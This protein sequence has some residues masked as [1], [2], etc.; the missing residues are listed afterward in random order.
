MIIVLLL[1]TIA[2]YISAVFTPLILTKPAKPAS[3][4]GLCASV[5]S[6]AVAVIGLVGGDISLRFMPDAIYGGFSLNID[7]LSAYF[8]LMT[9]VVGAAVS[10]YGVRYVALQENPRIASALGNLFLFLLFLI[11]SVDNSLEFIFVWETMALVTFLLIN[12]DYSNA[13]VNRAAWIYFVAAQAGAV[14]III[15]FTALYSCYQS[16]DFAVYKTAAIAPGTSIVIFVV[17]FIGFSIKAGMVPAHGWLPSAHAV[18]PGN[19]SA[20]LSG[21]ML[22]MALYGL[23]RFGFQFCAPDSYVV[24]LVVMAFGF[25]S[26]VYGIYLSLREREIKRILACS[27]IENM[28]LIF[29]LTGVSLLYK[30]LG[31][32]ILSLIALVA[33]LLH[34]FNHA[35][36]KSALFLCA[37]TVM[38]ITHQGDIEQLGGLM[39]YMP[40]IGW[41]FVLSGVAICGV[42]LFN[43]FISEWLM[44]KSIVLLTS[45]MT[46]FVGKAVVILSL[47]AFA[48]TIALVVVSF[49]RLL[50]VTFFGT[51]R[52]ALPH[53]SDYGKLLTLPQQLLIVIALVIGLLPGICVA[54][55]VA[56]INKMQILDYVR[57]EDFYGYFKLFDVSA[58]YPVILP[59]A[60][61]IVAGGCLVWLIAATGGRRITTKADPWC[62]GIVADKNMQYSAQGISQPLL[63]AFNNSFVSYF[64]AM[65][66]VVAMKFDGWTKFIRRMQSGN[67]HEYVAYVLAVTVILL[68]FVVFI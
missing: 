13:L 53:Y 65:L 39:K 68:I 58:A 2:T 56:T 61:V 52:G 42:P 19:I 10:L 4:L 17:A 25:F 41:T 8:L 46:G 62:C 24:A 12:S 21:A 5:L 57:I 48:A 66:A 55:L 38:K 29:A 1:L 20:L 26:A 31:Y 28:G 47:M 50:G 33:A 27:S 9:S 23:I 11:F 7:T 16:F 34:A 59:L 32:D 3:I 64:S 35:V 6:G 67:L 44:F 51:P 18:A 49:V 45:A 15:A 40:V 60:I 63:R 54:F 36:I 22:K 30:I 43:C 37:S 14:F